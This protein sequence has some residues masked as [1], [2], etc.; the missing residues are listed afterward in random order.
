MALSVSSH[1]PEGT[2]DVVGKHPVGELGAQERGDLAVGQAAVADH[3]GVAPAF[4]V[5]EV[6]E[7]A[8]DEL[9]DRDALLGAVEDVAA[10][11]DFGYEFG[12]GA[13]CF[14]FG[15]GHAPEHSFWEAVGSDAG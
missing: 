7:V 12:E 8:V 5:L 9:A 10:V 13:G 3:G 11:S 4:V 2:L 6:V 1:G 15:A 14:L